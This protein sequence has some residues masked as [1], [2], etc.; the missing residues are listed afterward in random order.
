MRK[1]KAKLSALLILTLFVSFVGSFASGKVSAS[2]DEFDTMRLKWRENLIGGT[3]YDVNDPIVSRKLNAL[4][5]TTWSTMDKSANR[6]YLWSELASPTLSTNVTQSYQRIKDMAVAYSTYGSSLYGN[7]QLKSDIIGALDWMYANRYNETR[8]YYDNWWDWEIGSPLQLNDT[9]V[10]MYDDLTPTQIANYM[11]PIDRF[12]PVPERVNYNQLVNT[13]ANLVWKCNIIALRGILVK[14]AAKLASARDGLSPVF[15]YVDV[16]DGFYEDGSFVQHD[17]FAYTGGYGVSLLQELGNV[18]YMLDGSSWEPVDPDAGRVYQW[19]YDAYEP[20][21]YDGAFMDM[22]RGRVIVRSYDQDHNTGNRAIAAIV[23]LTQMAPAADAARMKSMVKY[24]VQAEN[25]FDYYNDVNLT[26][27]RLTLDIVNDPAVQPRGE[28]IASKVY[29]GMDRAVH[30]RPGF[31]FGVSMSS[32]RIGTY[33]ATVGENMTAWYTGSGMTYLYNGDQRQYYD[34]WPTVNKYRLPGTTVDTM[35]RTD[36]EG[37]GYRSPKTF[38]G[39]SELLGQHSTVGMD[40]K[41]YGSSLTAKKSWFMFDDEVVALGAGISSTDNRT[42]ETTIENRMLNK[43]VFTKGIDPASPAAL[44]VGAEPLRHKVYAVTDSANDKILREGSFDNNFGTRWSGLGKGQW[45]QFD[46]GKIQPVGYVGISFYVQNTRTSAFDILVSTDNANWT[47]AFSGSSSVV[48]NDSIIQVFD[49]PDVQARYVKIVGKGNSNN[50][51]NSYNEVQIY[52]PSGAGNPIIPPSVTALAVTSVTDVTYGT[53][54]PVAADFDISTYWTAQADGQSL[55]LDMGHDVQLGYAGIAF[56]D[57]RLHSYPLDIETSQDQS[58]WS[59][60]YSGASAG[61]TSEIRAYDLADSTARYVKLTVHPDE[62][63]DPGKVSEIQLYAPNALGSVLDPLH[64]T[65]VAKGDEQFIVNGVSKPAVLGWEE[66][67]SNVSYAYLEGTGGYYFPEPAT[68]KGQRAASVGKYSQLTT[69]GATTDVSKNYLTMWYD[70]GKSPVNKDYSYVLLP[71]KSAAETASYS[72]NPDVE[73]VANNRNIQAVRE[74]TTNVFGANFWQPGTAG[75]VTAS[76]ASSITLKDEAGELDVAVSDPTQRQTKLTFEIF[77]KG[78]SVL[79]QDSTVTVLQLSPT[80]KFEVNTDQLNGRSH[81]VRFQ[82][83]DSVST[84][85]PTPSEIPPVNPPAEPKPDVM[86]TVDVLDD[87]TQVYAHSSTL[88]FER[89][90]PNYFN[91]DTSRAMR[92]SPRTTG[93][94]LVYKADEDREMTDFEVTTWFLPAEAKTDFQIYTSPDD[95]TYTLYTPTKTSELA[96][97]QKVK[98]SGSLPEGTKFLKIVFRLN[99]AYKWNPQIGEVRFTSKKLTTS[100]PP[101]VREHTMNDSL[102][103]FSNVFASSANL[104]FEAGN[105]IYFNGD[106]SRVTRKT[107]SAGSGEY[108]IY[109][110]PYNMDMTDFDVTT[111]FLPAEA[112]TDFQIYTSPDNDVYTLYTPTKTSELTGWQKVKYSGSLPQGTK[113]L[114]IV[115]RLNSAYAW[116]PQIGDVHITSKVPSITVTDD[117][118]DYSHMYDRSAHVL[119]T[120]SNAE[121][122]GNDA[123]RLVRTTNTAEYV[124]YKAEANMDLSRFTVKSWVF[125]YETVDDLE[126]YASPDNATYTLFTPAKAAVPTPGNWTEVNYSG[127]LPVGTQYLKIVFKP[128]PT[129]A[130]NPQIGTLSL[131]SHIM[132][133]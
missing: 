132:Y 77:R 11:K 2:Y 65:R 1:W 60:V 90:T 124:V 28:L 98:Y 6:T 24:W 71:N 102:N 82:Y 100:T 83:D 44:P 5:Q 88:D 53:P 103:D 8:A 58:V 131:T 36:N 63:G 41:A 123:S 84:P 95:L 91:G 13:G 125:P 122:I 81:A 127:N 121:H 48:A 86:T 7:Q 25:D 120:G 76:N 4:S 10:L 117:L 75:R 42:I 47:T 22:T 72:L 105:P 23:R 115:F 111:W 104:A 19:V 52:A 18:L 94:Y 39:G 54:V 20:L 87:Y 31:G 78:L 97:W 50:D 114:K 112:K 110:A 62:A 26:L 16:G 3:G 45:L 93:E 51:Y 9:V 30:L 37:T 33:E 126:F 118:N 85:L 29:A 67:M 116:N 79:A 59:S 80:I 96:G 113:Y 64:D 130:W 38:A 68:I 99:S 92:T 55:V 49:F 106:T 129:N 107:V 108:L 73:I 119:F 17:V 40:Y 66:E 128:S 32:N 133:P 27:A 109:K 15:D 34:Y 89:G 101:S 21:I 74:K 12:S 35:P 14:S 56:A 69:A 43:P 61:Q 57:G 46:L 70:H